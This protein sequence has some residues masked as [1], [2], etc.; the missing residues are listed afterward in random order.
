MRKLLIVMILFLSGCVGHKTSFDCPMPKNGA[1]CKSLSEVSKGLHQKEK[2][3][4][5]IYLK[6]E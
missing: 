5:V 6:G 4:N 2:P 1:T 3:K